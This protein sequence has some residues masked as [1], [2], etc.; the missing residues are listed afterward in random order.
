MHKVKRL[1][2]VCAVIV[3]ILTV[4]SFISG[5]S[6]NK[7]E[8]PKI[9]VFS[10]TAGYRHAS[11]PDG[12]MAIKKLGAERG[13]IV[14]TTEDASKF[15]EDTLRQYSA[16]IFLS[17]TH[18]VLNYRQ[19]ADFER[20]IEAGGG[21]VGIHA[22]ADCEYHW[23]WYGK[24]VG[25]YFKSHPHIQKATLDVHQDPK[26]PV[27]Q[28]LPSKWVRT[29]EWYNFRKPPQNVHVL[30]SI[31][32][33]SYEGGENGE[34]HPMV[35]YHDYDGG[36]AFYM[37]LGHTSESYTEANFLKLLLA[38]I[39]YAIG[40]NKPLDYSKS[41]A[42]RVP[43]EDRF[44]KQ[45]LA[46]GL[47]EPTEITVLPNLDILVGERKGNIKFY[48]A[49][50]KSLTLAAHINVYHHTNK[51]HTNVEMGLMGIQA[52]PHYNE[53]HWVY[54]YYSPVGKSVDRLSRFK[55]END[56]F[57][58]KSEQIILEV[59]TQ[60]DMCCHTGGSIAFDSNDNLFLSVGDNT[61]PFDELDP[62]TDKPYPINLHGYAPLDDRPGFDHYDD[63]RAAGN[64][65][66]LRGKILRIKVK[67]DGS[68]SI[69]DG[70]LFPKGTPKTRPEIYV[71]G[72]RNPYR[73][74][75]DKHTGFLY[76]GEVGPDADNDSL[77][78]RGPK[79]YDEINQARK[80]GNFGWPYFVGDNYAYHEYNYAT[81]KSGPAFD[82]V[83]LINDS[84]NNTGLRK[85][86]PAQPAFIW[87]PYGVSPD[88]PILGQG[89]RCSMAGPVY[90]VSDY[91]KATR[92]PDYYDGKLFIYDW[93]R[94]WIMAVTMNKEGDLQTIE[95]FMPHTT[96]ENISDM[97]VGKDGRIYEVE[98]GTGWFQK[99]ANSGLY[100]INYNGGNR[101][102]VV[103]L[104]ADKIAGSLPFTIHLSAKETKDPDG[105]KIKYSWNF[106]GGV[107]KETDTP[108]VSYEFDKAGEY[109]VSL[110][111]TDDKG[112]K[113]S[114]QTLE[115][116]AGNERPDVDISIEGNQ[117]FY[118]ADKPIVYRVH[119]SDN[120][121]GSSDMK[122]FDVS[123]SF[124]KA[125][126]LDS[127]DM[128]AVTSGHMREMSATLSGKSLMESLDCQS[129]HKIDQ[130]S[131]GPSFQQVAKKY[132]DDSTVMTH[133]PQKII[134][135]GSGVWGATAMAAHPGL[136]LTDSKKIVNWI[137]SLADEK[138]N[139][140]SLPL[141]G[142]INP[143]H[144]F[145]L[146]NQG[147]V[148]LTASYTDK[149]GDGAHPLIGSASFVLRNPFLKADRADKKSNIQQVEQDDQTY[150]VPSSSDAWL[151]YSHISLE[152]VRGIVIH[153][154]IQK[155]VEN[156]WKVEIRLGNSS[157]E[158]LGE[159]KIGPGIA[160]MKPTTAEI[161]F[162]KV[163]DDQLHNVYIVVHKLGE[164]EMSALGLIGFQLKA[165]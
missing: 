163:P 122:G 138:G 21:Y 151:E 6:V 32:E 11:I 85:L 57:N 75:V 66:D 40:G 15:N 114:S 162:T 5:C 58:L 29:D 100:V 82:P 112:A 37:E 102:P 119:I 33:T 24:L 41:T 59:K 134:K 127:P 42:L 89:G 80:A 135:G 76:W 123:R 54:V 84:R 22:A 159:Q 79:G 70:N 38:G 93:I 69:P 115:V 12:I 103:K 99:N 53:N 39:K 120:E 145:K 27:T 148:S 147:V 34:N 118:F 23:P 56:K 98:Y 90:Y 97:E 86:P 51:P 129:C 2:P 140:Q 143:E 164:S 47:D 1:N 165:E 31:D 13:F 43:D 157:G 17:T 88:F 146:N 48:N 62:K 74:S 150:S 61:T 44:S 77:K 46:T 156:G 125:D 128:A 110:T 94:N 16:V 8:I 92:L 64:T 153:Y 20:Y 149:G 144:K 50:N 142:K 25:A 26:F 14:D 124:V 137:L 107:A 83:N 106:G 121:D 68:Y 154:G 45:L 52:D 19:Q 158:L 96:F 35:W 3:C 60:R 131:I 113:A 78:T 139:T 67:P 130:K 117:T 133:L 136:S 10:K 109:P 104:K 160:P 7:R 73:I 95:P 30:V 108:D 111:V 155:K 49:S 91:P 28:A 63:R 161:Q 141:D 36:R 18:D 87:Y 71:M 81:G 101:P 116:T 65:N 4:A 152:G 9:L 105:D 55:F 126:Y 72:D 132:K